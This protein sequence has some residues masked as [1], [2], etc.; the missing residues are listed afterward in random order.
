MS[1]YQYFEWLTIDRTLTP[2]EQ[3]AVSRD[4]RES[5]SNKEKKL[6]FEPKKQKISPDWEIIDL[7][8]V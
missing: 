7:A 1:E 5:M 2:E 6:K 8:S 3:A 4:G